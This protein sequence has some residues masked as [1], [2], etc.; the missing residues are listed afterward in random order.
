MPLWIRRNHKDL[1]QKTT[2]SPIWSSYK[3][4]K[5]ST[6]KRWGI[7][8]EGNVGGHSA[9]CVVKASLAAASMRDVGQRIGLR[10]GPTQVK[11]Y[12]RQGYQH[13]EIAILVTVA[14]NRSQILYNKYRT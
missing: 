6:C 14:L 9:T 8:Q 7:G 13:D 5:C 10:V 3:S 11:D 4:G 12:R 1:N 2:V